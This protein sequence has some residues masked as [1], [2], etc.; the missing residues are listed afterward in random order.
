MEAQLQ[1]SPLKDWGFKIG[2]PLIISGPCSAETEEQV[3]Q[4]VRLLAKQNVHLIR[5][6]IWKP[7]T[8]PN[9]FEGV[10]S[11]GLLWLKNAGQEANLPVCVEVA[12]AKHVNEALKAGIDVLWIGARTTV[13]PFAVQ[14]IA[15]ALNG[16]N[17]PIMIKNPVNPDIDL[18]VGS[19]ERISKSGI[20]KIAAIHR[21]FSSYE[22]SKYRNKPHWEI[23]IELKRRIPELP[24][25]C[26]PSHICGNTETLLFIAQTAMDL[27]FDGLMLES[28]INPKK[29]LSDA[30]QQ[31]TPENL[32]ILLSNIILRR[33]STDDAKFLSKLEDLREQIDQMDENVVNILAERMGISRE[34]GQFKKDHNITILQPARWDE[35]VRNRAKQGTEKELTKDFVIRLFEI[36]HQESIHQQTL[37]M[38]TDV[39]G[40]IVV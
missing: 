38:N 39:S 6:G 9:S 23:P 35:I 15:D 33:V 11:I 10:G 12:N 24:L 21:G 27:N 31:I 25:I 36:I 29:A 20:K 7:R 16:V 3:L 37:V 5:A 26:D 30:K 32:S 34:I 8:R 40:K 4:T 18:W 2:S 19:I 1:I 28:H 13:N 14:E 17:I 22:K